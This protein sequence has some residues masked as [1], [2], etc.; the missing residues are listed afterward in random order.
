MTKL[1]QISQSVR[2]KSVK[3]SFIEEIK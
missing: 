1:K 2:Y 3:Y